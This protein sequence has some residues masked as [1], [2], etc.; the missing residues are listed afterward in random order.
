MVYEDEVLIVQ[1]SNVAG[2]MTIGAGFGLSPR[3]L[4]RPL[5]DCG[6]AGAAR[7]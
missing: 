5:P 2:V 6:D 4:V 7:C 1:R 3:L